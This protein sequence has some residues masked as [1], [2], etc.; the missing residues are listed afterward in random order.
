MNYSE[1][2]IFLSFWYVTKSIYLF[3]LFRSNYLS[4]LTDQSPLWRFMGSV[5]AANMSCQRNVVWPH[6]SDLSSRRVCVSTNSTTCL[7]NNFHQLARKILQKT[8]FI[9][10]NLL[11]VQVVGTQQGGSKNVINFSLIFLWANF[12]FSFKI[13]FFSKNKAF[14]GFEPGLSQRSNCSANCVRTTSQL[15]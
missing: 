3:A 14:A 5:S 12:L 7:C 2:K 8:H 15:E 6:K 9:S 13:T 11:C 1:V 4:Q 10:T